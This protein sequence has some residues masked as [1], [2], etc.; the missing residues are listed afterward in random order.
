MGE[1]DRIDLLDVDGEAKVFRLALTPLSLKEPAVEKDRL[2]GNAEDVAGPGN[3]ACGAN[4][5]DLHDVC[6]GNGTGTA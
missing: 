2:P 5:L 4:E 3:L 6:S 1:N